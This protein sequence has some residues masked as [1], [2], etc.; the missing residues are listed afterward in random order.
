MYF[1]K[2]NLRNGKK[3]YA[4]GKIFFFNNNFKDNYFYS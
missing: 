2:K 1:W 3:F 4:I